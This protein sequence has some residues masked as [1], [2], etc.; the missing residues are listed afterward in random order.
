MSTETVPARRNSPNERWKSSK[1]PS[2]DSG[3]KV[4]SKNSTA[5]APQ[6]WKM[7]SSLSDNTSS[8]G[9]PMPSPSPS[10]SSNVSHSLETDSGWK[11]STRISHRPSSASSVQS[12]NNQP[13]VYFPSTPMMNMPEAIPTPRMAHD[14]RLSF[15]EMCDR[16][17]S[18]PNLTQSWNDPNN[19]YHTDNQWNDYAHGHQHHDPYAYTPQMNNM[20]SP[21]SF[22]SPNMNS[23][24]TPSATPK[25]LPEEPPMPPPRKTT[26]TSGF[27]MPEPAYSAP[28]PIFTPLQEQIQPAFN[29]HHNQPYRHSLPAPSSTPYLPESAALSS[30]TPPSTSPVTP[31]PP[32]SSEPTPPGKK[33]KNRKDKDKG[34][35]KPERKVR[36]ITVPSINK[37]HRVWINVDPT[38]TGVSLAEKIH[39]IATFRTR[40]IL[41]ITT[42][43]GRQIPLDHRPIFGSW[44]DMEK[45]VDG[46]PWKVE[47]GDL[48]K[49]V[50]DKLFSKMVSGNRKQ[51]TKRDERLD[52]V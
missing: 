6:T 49:G 22:F 35:G 26:M 43:S 34:K 7:T 45:F 44:V 40:K 32:V 17:Q 18:A 1:P 38:E 13:A 30:I 2:G 8:L 28:T 12:S 31:V 37:E 47:W 9:M 27:G 3:W 39:I 21:A 11:M 33:E 42:A 16:R 46:E 14:D 15:D 52:R 24:M 23:M 48:D 50:V 29:P 10:F 51:P 19:A 5:L 25:P 4:S 41:S 36:Q 20:P